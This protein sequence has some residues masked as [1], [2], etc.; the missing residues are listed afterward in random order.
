[1]KVLFYIF[2]ITLSL[3]AYVDSDFDGVEDRYDKCPNTPLSDLVN[4]NGCSVKTLISPH[5]FDLIAG[6]SYANS[7]YQTLNQ[8]D[9]FSSYLQVDYYYK[10]FSLQIFSSYYTTSS[11]SY[12]DS[13]FNDVYIGGSYMFNITKKL[14]LQTTLGI[15]LPSYQSS[16]QN[17]KTD[18]TTSFN[19]SYGYEQWNLFSSL[20]YTFIGDTDILINNL[21]G[22][23]TTINYNNTLGYSAGVGY[24]INT[25]NYLSFSYTSTQSIYQGVE[26]LNTIGVYGYHSFT[27][28]YFT[29]FSYAYGLTQ[30]ASKHYLAL[31]IGYNF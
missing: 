30:S 23:T 26:D 17:N 25:A 3:Y 6:M 21:D 29:T 16:F 10:Q 19:L 28:T 1:M 14:H 2:F 8:T 27:D 22:T 13:G 24:H 4:L 11:S 20:N 18:Y 5:H 9:T 31:H 12:S 7:D 15:F